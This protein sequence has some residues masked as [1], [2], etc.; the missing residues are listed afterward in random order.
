[1]EA[2][3]KKQ[4]ADMRALLETL[5]ASTHQTFRSEEVPILLSE[6]LRQVYQH[7]KTE[8]E[9]LATVLEGEDDRLA[10]D[11]HYLAV[12]E[13]IAEIQFSLIRNQDLPVARVLPRMEDWVDAHEKL[14]SHLGLS[15][16]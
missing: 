10:Y 3:L 13:E 14:H 7:F 11:A 8:R 6:F 1:M 16:C 4:H 5:R 15:A 2:G 9:A 12:L